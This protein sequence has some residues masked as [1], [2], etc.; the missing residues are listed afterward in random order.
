MIQERSFVSHKHSD[1]SLPVINRSMKLGSY[2]CVCENA[3]RMSLNVPSCGRSLSL[4]I[5]FNSGFPGRASPQ[6]LLLLRIGVI[7]QVWQITHLSKQRFEC[8]RDAT[9]TPSRQNNHWVRVN[10][11]KS[12]L[13]NQQW[14]R[15]YRLPVVVCDKYQ[16]LPNAL[17]NLIKSIFCCAPAVLSPGVIE[18]TFF[19]F[20][21]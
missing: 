15:A 9:S 1:T 11:A 14:L 2:V 20:F 18:P 12:S 10:V 6:S 13:A 21:R 3:P 8:R 16:L 19:I 17:A 5:A 4:P 7:L